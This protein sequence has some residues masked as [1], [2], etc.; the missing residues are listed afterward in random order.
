M[1]I[2][3]TGTVYFGQLDCPNCS[4]PIL[5]NGDIQIKCKKCGAFM[6]VKSTKI[7]D[8]KMECI[9]NY[10]GFV[11]INSAYQNTC[12]NVCPAEYM[13]CKEHCKQENI[14]DQKK[15][16]KSAEEDLSEQKEKLK[17]IEASRKTWLITKLSGIDEEDTVSKD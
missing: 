5:F 3:I 17:L 14:D 13:Y 15:R 2:K 6:Q 7:V 12:F 11:C 8:Y 9:L 4:S 1:E 10:D 16:I